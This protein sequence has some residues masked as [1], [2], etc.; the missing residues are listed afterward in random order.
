LEKNLTDFLN[1]F[2]ECKGLC[3]SVGSPALAL[4]VDLRAALSSRE[5][6]PSLFKFFGQE[7]KHVHLSG[8]E[9]GLPDLREP[10]VLTA[11]NSI[12]QSEYAGYVSLEV[13]HEKI[14]DATSLQSVVTALSSIH[15]EM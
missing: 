2:D 12:A 5:S 15:A 8:P 6:V 3:D 14:P 1:S 10:V 11:L 13:P 9:M 7:I 4:H